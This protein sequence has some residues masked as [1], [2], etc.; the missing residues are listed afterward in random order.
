MG[1]EGEGEEREEQAGILRGSLSSWMVQGLGRWVRLPSGHVGM[2][3]A[4]FLAMWRS[5]PL[6]EEALGSGQHTFTAQ[7]ATERHRLLP[8]GVPKERMG[9]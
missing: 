1:L 2:G 3:F 9:R 6:A 5:G 4:H 7:V 8:A